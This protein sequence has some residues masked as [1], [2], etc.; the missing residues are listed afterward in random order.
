MCNKN[1]EMCN[2]NSDN[3]NNIA[4]IKVGCRV[5]LFGDSGYISKIIDE[6]KCVVRIRWDSG[7]ETVEIAKNI[8]ITFD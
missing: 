2:E 3:G 6:E 4:N 7:S 1:V 8:P 5:R